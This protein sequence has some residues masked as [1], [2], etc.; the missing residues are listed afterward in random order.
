MCQVV[1]IYTYAV[2][3]MMQGLKLHNNVV[4][5]YVITFYMNTFEILKGVYHKVTTSGT[6]TE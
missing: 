5:K 4:N 1:F 3:G 2:S 6:S